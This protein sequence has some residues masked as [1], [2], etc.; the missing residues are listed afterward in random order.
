MYSL[1]ILKNRSYIHIWK[2]ETVHVSV[3]ISEIDILNIF[4]QTFFGSIILYK[5]NDFLKITYIIWI[6]FTIKL[7]KYVFLFLNI[8]D[9]DDFHHN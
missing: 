9:Q 7:A 3:A 6:N 1:W 2:K 4:M 8:I 5:P